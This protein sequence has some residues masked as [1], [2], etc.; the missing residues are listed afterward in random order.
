SPSRA[1]AAQS[2]RPVTVAVTMAAQERNATAL[3]W[4]RAAE[5]SRQPMAL[6]SRLR[7]VYNEGTQKVLSGD[8]SGGRR[9]RL[10]FGES[11]LGSGVVEALTE[12]RG[13][14]GVVRSPRA[15]RRRSS[16]D[17]PCDRQGAGQSLCL[18]RHYGQVE[19]QTLRVS[20]RHRPEPLDLPARAARGGAARLPC[21]RSDVPNRWGAGESVP[22]YP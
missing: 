7:E 20:P 10:R 2:S 12:V 4:L 15:T 21:H 1:S 3:G 8:R 18:A 6:Q 11:T 9:A 13:I 19:P 22:D 16:G 5:P 17:R 14:R